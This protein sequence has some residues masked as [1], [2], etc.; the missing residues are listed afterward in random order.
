MLPVLGRKRDQLVQ[1]VLEI[2]KTKYGRTRIEKVEECVQDW[3]EFKE[4]QFENED[5]LLLAM[6]EIELRRKELEMTQNEWFSV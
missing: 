4:D 5:E 1:R 6:E 3:I 2:L